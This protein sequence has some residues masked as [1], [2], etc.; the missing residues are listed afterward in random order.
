[1]TMNQSDV[2]CVSDRGECGR[3]VDLVKHCLDR[4]QL[5]VDRLSE[6]FD[7]PTPPKL[8]RTVASTVSINA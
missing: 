5:R 1:M 8:I 4:N 6:H 2:Q 7:C 3:E